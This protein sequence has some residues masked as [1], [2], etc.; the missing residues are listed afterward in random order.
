MDFSLKLDFFCLLYCKGQTSW[1]SWRH[2]DVELLLL[3]DL[4]KSAV[5]SAFP[6][7][8]LFPLKRE[9]SLGSNNLTF[10][11]TSNEWFAQHRLFWLWHHTY[12][13]EPFMPKHSSFIDTC[14]L[15]IYIHDV[16]LALRI[17]RGVLGIFTYCQ[18]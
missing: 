17:S 7:W 4:C 9:K 13:A 12:W 2:D 5:T 8:S 6:F 10:S 18:I 3:M 14:V 1:R 16:H 11:L 15:Y